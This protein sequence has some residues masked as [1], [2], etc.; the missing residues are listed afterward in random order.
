MDA[1]TRVALAA[2]DGDRDALAAFVERPRATCGG[3]CAYLV[4][5]AAADDAAQ[6][7]W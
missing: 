3:L 2:R 7:T 1:L 5:R 4:G 6:E